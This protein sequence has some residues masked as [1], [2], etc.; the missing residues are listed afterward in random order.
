MGKV[1]YRLRNYDVALILPHLPDGG[2]GNDGREMPPNA[3][4][5]AFGLQQ[6]CNKSCNTETR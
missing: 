5:F 1:P 6:S 4:S 2:G 3:A